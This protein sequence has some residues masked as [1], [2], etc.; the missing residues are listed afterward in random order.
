MATP[1]SC[2]PAAEATLNAKAQLATAMQE[3]DQMPQARELFHRA[4]TRDKR[5]RN[6]MALLRC[7]GRV[8][9][10]DGNVC[11]LVG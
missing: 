6:Q 2:S 1:L 5:R 10:R 7:A 8:R 4:G 9:R 11:G 3:T